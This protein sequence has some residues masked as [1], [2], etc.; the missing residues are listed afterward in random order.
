[1]IRYTLL[2]LLLVA[3]DGSQTPTDAAMP[4]GG[5]LKD[6]S[7]EDSS[8]PLEDAGADL[9]A[10]PPV[11]LGDCRP[12]RDGADH[13]SHVDC[14]P[15]R[16]RPVCDAI[17]RRCVPEPSDVCDACS[18][19]AQCDDA[20]PGT[21]CVF[22]APAAGSTGLVNGDSACLW[23]CD[24]GCEWLAERWGR[25]T[26]CREGFCVPDISEANCRDPMGSGRLP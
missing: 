24:M 20:Q 9:D 12:F 5:L 19:Q 13:V 23:P 10:A 16:G 11:E 2:A 25:A 14:A 1:M 6:A 18:S 15:V 8:A 3:C 17:T 22:L 21:S 7:V 26:T 4:D